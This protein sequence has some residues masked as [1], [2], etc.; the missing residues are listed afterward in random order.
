[1]NRRRAESEGVRLVGIGKWW[2]CGLLV[3]AEIVI[4]GGGGFGKSC[5]FQI[6]RKFAEMKEKL[7]VMRK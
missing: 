4:H 1:M 5:G 3:M 7:K 6:R 2:I